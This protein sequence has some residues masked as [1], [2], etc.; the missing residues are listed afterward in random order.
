MKTYNTVDIL[1][2][3]RV[4]YWRHAVSQTFVPLDS[5]FSCQQ[6]HGQL[7][8]GVWGAL[9]LSEVSCSAQKVTRC[10][11]GMSHHPDNML[12]LSFISRGKTA[13]VQAGKQSTLQAGEFGLYDTR[14][15]YEL[16]LH[17]ENQQHVVQVPGK[18]LRQRL[19]K[20]EHLVA[21]AFGKQHPMMPFLQTLL[22]NVMMQPEEMASKHADMLYEQFL[23]L[24]TLI[25]SDECGETKK[26]GQAQQGLLFQIKVMI[27]Q[28]LDEPGLSATH[29]ADAFGISSR[30]LSMLLQNEETSF[31]RYVLKQRLTRAA[32]ELQSPLH[33]AT[34]VGQIAWRCGFSD[35][36]YFSRVFRM[37]FGCTPTDYRHAGEITGRAAG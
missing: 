17:G 1:Y 13:V 27:N 26:R 15:P 33:A 5:A 11:T 4:D 3:D 2:A 35:V 14:F 12:L 8:A 30:Y 20:T 10:R 6:R 29:I 31:G 37:N 7:R 21:H 9:R 34:P 18:H 28:R 24:L 23:D 32:E 36:A 25:I 22:S 16:H 19:G